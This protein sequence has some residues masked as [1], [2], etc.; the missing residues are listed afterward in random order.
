M[1]FSEGGIQS[2]ANC[3]LGCLEVESR[4]RTLQCVELLRAAR[5]LDV[6]RGARFSHRDR[7]CGDGV[8]HGLALG[9]RLCLGQQGSE[10]AKKKRRLIVDL[11][12]IRQ[13]SSQADRSSGSF[14]LHGLIGAPCVEKSDRRGRRPRRPRR[15]SAHGRTSNKISP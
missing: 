11:N 3:I 5:L 8:R 1:R 2:T 6:A 15:R 9:R 4:T 14:S 13:E 7:C 12:L 10:R